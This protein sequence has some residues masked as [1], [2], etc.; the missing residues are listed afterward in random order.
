M[1][2]RFVIV[3]L[4]IKL[5]E[6][7]NKVPRPEQHKAWAAGAYPGGLNHALLLL[8]ELRRIFHPREEHRYCVGDTFFHV[9]REKESRLSW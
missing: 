9:A 5:Q 7:T 1:K 2:R 6:K 3:N 8:L 4:L